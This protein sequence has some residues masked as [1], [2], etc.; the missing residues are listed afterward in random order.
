MDIEE[1]TFSVNRWTKE[2][3]IESIMDMIE[4]L[5]WE[6]QYGTTLPEDIYDRGGKIILTLEY[7]EE[8]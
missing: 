2:G 4:D 6:I 7:Y 3:D 1:E 8:S 5:E